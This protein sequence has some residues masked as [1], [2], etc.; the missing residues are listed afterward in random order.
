[1]IAGAADAGGATGLGAGGPVSTAATPL[2]RSPMMPDFWKSSGY[3]LLA[4]DA[5]G[6]LVAGDDFLRAYVRRPEMRPVAESCAAERDLHAA[7]LENPRMPVSEATIAAMADADARDN[8]RTLLRFRDRLLARPSLEAAYLSCFTGPID[9]PPLF[10]DQMAHVILRNVLDGIEDGMIARAGELF[11]RTQKVTIQEGAILLADE[12]V[13]EM[14]ALSGGFGDLGR[15]IVET[16]TPLKSVELDVLGEVTASIYFD[17]DERHDTVLDLTFSRPGL[18]ALCRVLEAWLRHFLGVATSIQPV[19]RISD[20]RWVWHVGLDAEASAMLND[21]YHGKEL[22]EQRL[23][24]LLSLFRL[25]FADPTAMRSDI[26][27]RPVYLGLAM[28]EDSVLRL[29]PQNLLVNLPL[30]APA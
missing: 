26:A 9:I 30:A 17:R 12:E 2:A 16:R 6:R 7:L 24:R 28:S 4:H 27:G 8:Y 19:Q 14:Y 25:E 3:G 21:L 18:D 5:D 15:L 22:D 11:F 13:V 10:L 29:K 20:E 23:G 1:M